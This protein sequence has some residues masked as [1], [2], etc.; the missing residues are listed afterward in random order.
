MMFSIAM[1]VP[2]C[3]DHPDLIRLPIVFEESIMVPTLQELCDVIT[4]VL[5]FHNLNFTLSMPDE[6]GFVMDTYIDENNG[7]EII[8][9]LNNEIYRFVLTHPRGADIVG[10]IEKSESMSPGHVIL[11]LRFRLMK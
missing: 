2:I 7:E 9:T 4:D 10:K 1:P 6:S 8:D 3:A 11:I 5:R